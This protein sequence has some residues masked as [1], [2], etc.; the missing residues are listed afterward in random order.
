MSKTSAGPLSGVRVLDV[1]IMA[2]GPWAG[3]LLGMLGAEVI[4]IE[5]PAGDSMRFVMPTQRGMGTNYLAMNANKSS[6][7]LNLKTEYGLAQA[8]QLAAQ[9]DVFLQNFRVGVIDRLGLGYEV[10]RK[11]NPRII[12]CSI[13]GFGER[14]PMANA[15]CIDTIMQAFS[16]FAAMNGATEDD[17]EAFRFT[18]FI[19]LA[20][21]AVAVEATLAA[22][23]E[24]DSSGKGQKVEVSMLE[25]AL[26]MQ[27]TRIA[28]LLGS[29]MKPLPLGSES[30]LLAPDRAFQSLDEEVFVTV[31]SEKEWNGFCNAL[32]QNQLLQDERFKSNRLRVRN[33][34]ALNALIAPIIRSKA[35]IW[36]LRVM[37]R[38][39][40]PCALAHHF[41][42]FRHHQQIVQ[43]RM[44]AEIDT[45]EWG[46]LSLG[47]AP[48]HFSRTSCDLRAP[49]LLDDVGNTICG[50]SAPNLSSNKK[51]KPYSLS[52]LRIVEW[53]EGIAGPL[54]SVRL[55]DLGADVVKVE[56]PEG[57]WL[58]K[59]APAIDGG[60][61][62]A[63]FCDLNRG[64]KSIVMVEETGTATA[65]L[66]PLLIK[67]D[68]FITDRPRNVL[69][70]LGIEQ[71]CSR[72]PRLIVIHISPFGDKGPISSY[73]GSE[74]TAQAMAGYTRYLGVRGEP[75][76]RLGADVASVGT[77]IFAVQA[78][79]A[80]LWERNR[81]GRG[82]SVSLSLLNSSICM[83][84]IHLAAQGDPDVYA[85]PRVA[86]AT[87]PPDR[88]W[89][90]A[91]R[92]IYFTFGG[93]PGWQDF[94]HEI[95]LSHLLEDSRFLDKTGR[96]STGHGNYSHLVR[97][98]YEVAFKRY[99]AEKL[100]EIIR[101]HMGNAG[102][103][104]RAD[105]MLLDPQTQALE[106]VVSVPLDS[107]RSFKVR[108][109]PAKFSDLK[110]Q[111]KGGVATLGTDRAA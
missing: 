36:W 78:A 93:R 88:G 49:V 109:F 70:E 96:G 37:Q 95:G 102:V 19:D 3:A 54:A 26:E 55:G 7:K 106:I 72:N 48:W 18:G 69:A 101:R 108:A 105:E 82:Q 40:V 100:L 98:E 32:D 57:D 30:P 2:A 59:A 50:F 45:Q 41:E 99:S 79:L 73:Q 47:G 8:M 14:G 25:A 23:A 90:T 89:R 35:A 29:G 64:K 111:I 110:P 51:S 31:H 13:S 94:M 91:D 6:I 92:R 43:N 85:G 53:S 21:A 74:L 107:K 80:A 71:V 27:G 4:K 75:A 34:I 52:S 83:K 22:L 86:G 65:I 68:V 97:E 60:E 28:E 15:G 1:S 11:I 24:R 81:S 44:I 66:E 46:V 84:T 87:F 42:T 5:S 38:N 17:L 62:S 77:G 16:G 76:L 67:A 103:F 9:C 61:D 63:A 58:R 104:Q 39:S 12:Y 56:S 33:R 20:T 10:L